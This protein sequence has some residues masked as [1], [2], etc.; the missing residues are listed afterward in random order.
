MA[1]IENKNNQEEAL[2]NASSSDSASETLKKDVVKSKSGV[3]Y[4]DSVLAVASQRLIKSSVR[5]LNLVAKMIRG[6]K[7]SKAVSQLAFCPKKVSYDVRKVLMSAIANAENNHGLD[8]DALYV[9]E[10][11]VGKAMTLKRFSAR[12]KGRG[13]RINKEFS[14]ITV[15][16]CEGEK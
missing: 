12:A 8:I 2:L 1:S 13:T 7:A 3:K 14:K 4:N 11:Y 15:V 6:V 16:L 5:K 10:A 9:K